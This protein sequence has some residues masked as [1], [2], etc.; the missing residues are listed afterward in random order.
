MTYAT[1]RIKLSDAKSK[2]RC[3]ERALDEY[4]RRHAI[5]N[6]LN[7]VARSFILE[8]RAADPSHFPTVLGF[9]ALSMAVVS[10]TDVSEHVRF[11]VPKYP[12]PAMLI[13]RLAVDERTQGHRFGEIL[14]LDALARSLEVAQL[15]GC[16]RIVVDAKHA[17]AA[18]FY[19]K[20]G[21]VELQ[22]ESW[23]RRL[24]IAMGTVRAALGE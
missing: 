12:L 3:R 19:A 9:Y 8:R 22:S 14:L 1:R 10:S 15:L 23:P 13:G 18:A 6:D 5:S 4:L 20:Y 16:I 24:F 21:F 17:A 11:N 7:G 2:F